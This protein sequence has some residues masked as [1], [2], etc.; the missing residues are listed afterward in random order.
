M[1]VNQPNHGGPV[2]RVL[3]HA[4]GEITHAVNLN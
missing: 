1:R 2:L 3:I 4:V